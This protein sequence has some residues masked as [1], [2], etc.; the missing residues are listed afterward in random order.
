MI[1]YDEAGLFQN[2]IGFLA[3]QEVPCFQQIRKF[4][5]APNLFSWEILILS[6]SF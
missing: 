6:S 3:G 1:I 2:M 4:T 5:A